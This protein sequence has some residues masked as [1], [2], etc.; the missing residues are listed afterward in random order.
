MVRT[1]ITLAEEE[2]AELKRLAAQQDRSVSWLL[3]QA[4][5]LS[6][7]RLERGEPYATEFDRIWRE[8]GRSLKQVGV[9]TPRDVDHLVRAVRAG[10]GQGTEK[11]SAR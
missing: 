4:F 1:T 2:F 10:K 5:R 7:A 9:R 11:A 6:K 3:R 8:V